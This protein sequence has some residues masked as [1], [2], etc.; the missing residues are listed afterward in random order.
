MKRKG[1]EKRKGRVERKGSSK[2]VKM[3]WKWEKWEG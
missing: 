3:K 1:R 2:R